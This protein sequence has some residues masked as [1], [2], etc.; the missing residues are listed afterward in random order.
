EQ[1]ECFQ[2]AEKK[3]PE[4]VRIVKAGEKH[5]EKSETFFLKSYIFPG[6]LYKLGY[7]M[8]PSMAKSYFADEKC[9]GCGI[10]RKVCPV[11][12]IQIV[13][14]RPIWNS[15]CQQCYACLQWC[16][17]EAIQFGKKTAT[18]KRYRNPNIKINEIIS[19]ASCPT[20]EN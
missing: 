18:I 9:N 13:D 12:N 3:I 17:Q 20:T 16:P 14:E 19:S 5:L 1:Q 4:I 10:C 2:N 8:I 15:H 11:D 7:R 6:L